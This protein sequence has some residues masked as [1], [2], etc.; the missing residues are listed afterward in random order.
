MKF[1]GRRL[2]FEALEARQLLAADPIITEFM[3]SN[4]NTLEDGNGATPDWIEIYNNGD[5]SVD[6][7]GY[8]LT[9]DPGDI[10][11]WVFPSTALAAGEYLIVFASGNNIPDSAGYLHT[12]FSLQA[13]GEYVALVDP[14]GVVLSEYGPGGVDYPAQ[15]EDVSYGLAYDSDPT[16]PITPGSTARYLIP[17]NNAVD[18]VWTNP[19]FDDTSWQSGP[20]SMG[21]ETS[22]TNYAD[23][24]LLDTLV[25]A[26][27]TTIYVRAEFIIANADTMLDKLQLK[28]DDGFVAYIN[29][30]LVASDNAPGTLAYDSVATNDRPDSIAI[31]YADFDISSYSSALNVGTNV[32]AIHAL[33][34]AS[35]SDMLSVPNLLL[36]AGGPID[37]PVI[38]SLA[39]PTPGLPNTNL[40]ASDVSFS[41]VGGVFSGSF[42]LTMTASP[43]ETIRYTTDGSNPDENSATYT[44]PITV[45][46][47]T[48]Y[49]A[50][51]YGSQGQVGG[52]SVATYVASASSV[53]NFNSDLP[54]VVLENFGGGLPDRE[55]QDS[56]FALYD[57]DPNTGRSSLSNPADI[58]M[59]LGQHRRGKSTYDSQNDKPNLRIELRDEFGADKNVSLLGMPSESDWILYAPWTIDRAMV[60][61]ALIY[62]LSRQAG[63]WASRTRFVEVY[64]NFDGGTLSDNDYRG[65]YVLMEV[66]K[67]DNSRVDIEELTPSQNSAPEITGGYILQID[68]EEPNDESW[69]TS[70]GTNATGGHISHSEPERTDLTQTQVDYIRDYVQDAEDAL[71]GPNS[72]DP[73]LGYQAYFDV[74]AAV[75]FHLFNVFSGNPD[76]FRLSTYL[77]KDRN[78]KL[79]FGPLWDF[80]RGMGPD[81]DNRAED[82]TKWMVDENYFWVRFYFNEMLNDPNFLQKWVDRWHELRQTV[83]SNA[84]LESTLLGMTDQLT[85][86]Q[87]RNETRYPGPAPNGGPLADPGDTGWEGEVSHL[88]NW[89][90]MR[91]DWID[92]LLIS[93]PSF[94]PS[95]GNVTAGTQVTLSSP[96]STAIY[97]TL[98]GSDPRASGGSVSPSALLYTSPISINQSVQINARAFGTSNISPTRTVHWSGLQQGLF[99]V[100]VAADATNLRI[101]ELQY[102]PANP[103]PAELVLVPDAEDDDFEFI[104]LL[105]IGNDP[106]SLN[107]V[108]FTDGISFDFSTSSVTS[109]APG[110]TVVVV[111]NLAA[112]DARYGSGM[113]IAGQYSGNLSNGGEQI[114]LLDIND[115][116]INDF[117]YSDDAPWPTIADGN[118]PSL[119]VVITSGNYSSPSN[120]RASTDSEN[121]GTPGEHT[122]SQPGDINGDS[123]VS[124]LDFLAWQRGAGTTYD[125]S[126]LVEWE[127]NYGE[128]SVAALVATQ[129]SA[130]NSLPSAVESLAT[131]STTDSIDFFIL[132]DFDFRRIDTQ[133]ADEVF[134]N[135]SKPSYIDPRSRSAQESNNKPP[136][137]GD[138]TYE[139]VQGSDHEEGRFRE[140]DE[141]TWQTSVDEALSSP[142]DSRE[143]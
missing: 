106:I 103:T 115:Q 10:N 74:D 44:G 95:P 93:P 117:S 46:S 136:R 133:T 107:G 38:G 43:G 58:A 75:D 1:Q 18:A 57:V 8:R 36:T 100:E 140:L 22:G 124:G 23:A 25:P 97:Y 113:Q 130:E 47:T 9:D 67:R 123:I 66:I 6:L 16:N 60:R 71:F 87:V 108:R 34:K 54:V 72:T 26:G 90:T 89:L 121:D 63:N 80:D 19:S 40:R 96:G 30:V 105:N 51:A 137:V 85:E 20:I 24:G 125:S 48:Q 111:E 37:P 78:G 39:S 62:D 135:N 59:V 91:A 83:F 42:L 5:A 132:N 134:T 27:T 129:S 99:S 4:G 81:E 35:S 82:P 138:E 61:H 68:E 127:N 122:L 120:W 92:T 50:R 70:R 53:V 110:E 52:I 112:F 11:K 29:G 13:G 17:S 69:L 65:I 102:H 28:Y 12:N 116:V 41:R 32:L 45:N 119:E 76:A 131:E 7:A 98:D 143:I 126:D 88:K 84:N 14:S 55:F 101:T 56:S 77:T 118:G 142:F 114:T 49:R 94:S 21:Y 15:S 33:N 2:S 104:E 141:D 86:A 73:A 64:S 128:E 139:I 3:A 79:A 109:L 31:N